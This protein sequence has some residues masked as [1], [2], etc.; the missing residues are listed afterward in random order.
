LFT[1]DADGTSYGGAR[2][3]MLH[4]DLLERMGALPGVRLASVS[5][6][7]PISGYSQ[8]RGI[9]VPGFTSRSD[10]DLEIRVNW[11]GPNYFEAMGI[12]QIAGRGFSERDDERAPRVAV[13]NES[14]ARYYFPNASPVGK[15]ITVSRPPEGGECEIIGVVRDARFESLRKESNRM[16]YLS[17]LQTPPWIPLTFAL[18]TAGDPANLIAAVRREVRATGKDIPITNVKTLRAQVDES[19]AQERLVTTLS[20]FFGLLAL[21]LSSIGLYGVISYSVSRRT[22]DVGIR[23]A[24]GARGLDVLKLLLKEGMALVLIGVATG[25][26]ASFAL[27]R[28]I[29]SLLFG[30]SAADAVTFVLA[31]SLLVAITLLACYLPARRAWIPWSRCATNEVTHGNAMAGR[32]V[33]RADAGEIAGVHTGGDCDAR[34]RHRCQHCNLQCRVLGTVA[35]LPL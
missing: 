4:R 20:S 24:L 19:L 12:A 6:Y 13:I 18:R 27:T 34:A 15:R 7:S 8:G 10:G 29:E 22:H 16:V 28:L 26:T 5:N 14:M 21:L 23:M 31:S 9:S 25:L 2:L 35:H 3:S 1:I 33:R 30:V 32:E 11:V 17:T